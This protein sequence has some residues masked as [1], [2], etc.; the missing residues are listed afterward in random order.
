MQENCF[1]SF[2]R[3]VDYRNVLGP[4]SNMLFTVLLHVAVMKLLPLLFL[5]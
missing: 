1:V 3:L 5:M 2:K 4:R